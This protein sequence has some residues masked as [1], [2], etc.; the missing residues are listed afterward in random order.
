MKK[1]SEERIKCY[2][3]CIETI[4]SSMSQILAKRQ[5]SEDTRFCRWDGQSEDGKKHDDA[6]GDKAM[7]FEGAS[8]ARIYTA[9]MLINEHV[10]ELVLAATRAT[11]KVVG[12]ESTDEYKAG[13][14]WAILKW[15]RETQWGSDFRDQLE[16]LANYQEGDT[17]AAAVLWID[18]VQERA[19]EMKQLSVDDLMQEVMKEMGEAATT[20]LLVDLVR[21]CADPMREE[22]L[23]TLLR[24]MFPNVSAGTAKK[25]AQSLQA[26]QIAEFPRPYFRKNRPEMKAL[27]LYDDVFIRT[28]IRE[29]QRAPE[30]FR[31]EWLIKAEVKERAATENWNKEFVKKL[32]GDDEDDKG[33]EAQ[34]CFSDDSSNLRTNPSN[35]LDLLEP[36]DGMY[37]LLTC[38]EYET[39]DDGV[40]GIW[41]TVFSGLID[42]P[43]KEP[44]LFD[45]KHGK[46]PAVMFT[47]ELTGARRLDS[48]GISEIVQTVQNQQKATHDAVSDHVQVMTNPPLKTGRGAPKFQVLL[49]PFGQVEAGPREDVS[50][51][52]RPP[53]PEAAKWMSDKLQRD[54]NEYYGRPDANLPPS[55]AQIKSQ[56]RIDRFLAYLKDA[57]AMTI[58]LIQQF[59]T[60]E[61]IQ[62][63][64]NRGLQVAR[65]VEE[66]QGQ[67][68]LKL[69]FDVRDLDMEF[70]KLKADMYATSIKALDTRATVQWDRGVQRLVEAVDPF[71]ADEMIMP[72]NIADERE[73]RE[74]KANFAKIV[75]GVEPEMTE[76]G[77][78]AQA[79]IQVLQEMIGQRQ[80]NPSAFYPLSPASQAILDNRMK[81]LEFQVQQ[82]KNAITGKFGTEP[83]DTAM[84]GAE[85]E[86]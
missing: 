57:Y 24:N 83:V 68:D 80:Q 22:E 48:R 53:F 38:Y 66:I 79:R 50:F 15:L 12:M 51:L 78:N 39:D 18:W 25:A 42:I 40:L 37:E 4:S 47:R 63:I 33:F 28:N 60:D 36:R 77:I 41:V 46:Y 44:E 55:M 56:A 70:V 3:D 54:V 71:A 2:H 67:Y 81:Y 86:Q 10:D 59:M 45:R 85:G 61:D 11:P 23:A 30:L 49:A 62:R 27:R 20:D 76:G 65:T 52:V 69:S 8:D 74:E 14:M 6:I 35:G 43:A 21:M 32:I 31:R 1:T 84:I 26:G 5:T 72:T 58:Q 13:K 17:P 19:L 73:T 82:Q 34:S 16:I 75:A 9:D 64:T 29:F 7:P